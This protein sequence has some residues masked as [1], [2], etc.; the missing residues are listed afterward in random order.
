MRHSLRALALPALL[1]LVAL[2][3]H[4]QDDAPTSTARL[5]SAFGVSL[6]GFAPRGEFADNVDFAGGIGGH[7][8]FRLD[9]DG[10]IGLRV[11]GGFLVYGSEKYRTSL[12]NGPLGLIQVD[13][14]TS[15][16]IAYGGIGLQLMTPGT[17][18]RPYAHAMAGFS[19]FFTS[20]SVEGTNDSEAFASSTNYSDGG[21]MWSGGGGLLI[22]V[23]V[24]RVVV[25]IDLGV[26]WMDNRERDYLRDDGITFENNEVQLNPVRSEAKG[27][28]LNLGVAISY[29]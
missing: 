17:T 19:Y 12:G 16:N 26:R 28:K 4:A 6:L 18:V 14:N 2:P 5:R 24:R 13:V 7:Y 29:R 1:A 21:F 8:L 20:S 22:P 11:D 23:S 10:V 27:L 9:P 15:N 25:N 3:V